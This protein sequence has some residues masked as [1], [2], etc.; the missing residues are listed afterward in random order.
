VAV[1]LIQALAFATQERIAVNG[2]RGYDGSAYY[3]YAAQLAAGERP[4]GEGRFVRRIGTPALAAVLGPADLISAFQ[5]INAV[6]SFASALLLLA[7]L[8]LYLTPWLAAALAILYS[9]HWLAPVRFTA[10]YPVLVDACAQVCCFAGLLAIASYERDPRRWKIAAVAA[11]GAA[12]VCFREAVLLVP[13]AFLFVRQ[14]G[15]AGGASGG[16][17][18]LAWPAVAWRWVTRALPAAAA[19]ATLAAIDAFVIATDAG[20]RASDHLLDRALSRSPLTFALG[21]AVAFGPALG[22][23]LFDWRQ[24]LSFARRHLWMVVFVLGVAA[25]GWAG[26]LESERHAINWAAPV[27]YLLAGLALQRH[28][29]HARPVVL[30]L[31]LLAQ[32]VV[33]RVFW[34]VPQADDSPGD[35]E[36]LLT[37]AGSGAAYLHLFPD[38]LDR[39]L[40]R[41]QLLQHLALGAAVLL[42]LRFASSRAAPAGSVPARTGSGG[43]GIV[44]DV[45]P[46]ALSAA[47]GF[48]ACAAAAA[49]VVFLVVPSGPI[50]IHVRWAPGVD[51]ASRAA[52][53][54]QFELQEAR[55][56]EGTTWAY[57]LVNPTTDRIRAIV[58]HRAVEDTAHVNRQSYRPPF[59]RDPW[60][61]AVVFGVLAG[62]AGGC[63]VVA[64]TL[65]S[66]FVRAL[67]RRP[68]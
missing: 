46:L 53:E 39:E 42:L 9:T 48:F 64:A 54:R 55:W 22:I 18:A 1:L 61:M 7:W 21:W 17:R 26:S 25:I 15:A 67:A 35:P 58:T 19:L 44:F 6:A 47:A 65:I 24:V 37:V 29:L 40:A 20:F 13:V 5:A 16:R 45:V 34:T 3:Q 14:A 12:G 27:V 57:A 62:L 33:H 63:A 11:I 59:A 52:L 8:R 49:V 66:P 32:F 31:I 50:P 30:A 4:A 68:H 38:Y 10:F 41:L 56:T 60:R 23:V 51:A 36:I 28:R 2:G 43:A